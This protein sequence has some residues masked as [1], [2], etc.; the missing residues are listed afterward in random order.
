[1]MMV[2]FWWERESGRCF[3]F[4]SLLGIENGD[5]QDISMKKLYVAFIFTSLW[6]SRD[7]FVSW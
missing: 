1:M 3:C 4:M 2:M 6:N 5:E 7:K